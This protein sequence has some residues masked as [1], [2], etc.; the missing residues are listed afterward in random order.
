MAV[1]EKERLYRGE[2]GYFYSVRL[3]KCEG[4]AA[5]LCE[6]QRARVNG[7]D[8]RGH[9]AARN[10][11]YSRSRRDIRNSLTDTI[12]YNRI[13]GTS[14]P[15]PDPRHLW[16]SSTNRDSVSSATV[17][18]GKH[19][20]PRDRTTPSS[21]LKKDTNTTFHNN[22]AAKRDGQHEGSRHYHNLSHKPTGRWKP[23]QLRSPRVQEEDSLCSPDGNGGYPSHHSTGKNCHPNAH[24]TPQDQK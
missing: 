5:G 13:H 17:R 1:L 14:G 4:R 16:E 12:R 11:C 9:H 20:I 6:Q 8:N 10:K 24:R 22:T 2:R 21:I 3:L 19:T 18:N 23:V 7:P 15:K